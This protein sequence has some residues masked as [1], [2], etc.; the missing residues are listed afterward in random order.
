M[1]YS[2]PS[3]LTKCLDDPRVLF[4]LP[5]L[6]PIYLPHSTQHLILCEIQRILEEACFKFTLKWAAPLLREKKWECPAS[7]E[8]TTWLDFFSREK[9]HFQPE[10]FSVD[11]TR[12]HDIFSAAIPIRHTAVHRLR[13]PMSR[14]QDLCQHGFDLASALGD[15]TRA[16]KIRDITRE[17]KTQLKDMEVKKVALE[18]EVVNGL[19]AILRQRKIL[20]EKQKEL[21]DDMACNDAQ[22]TAHVGSLLEDETRKIL[23]GCPSTKN[24][25]RLLSE[26]AH[27]TH[28]LPRTSESTISTEAVEGSLLPWT[29][30]KFAER[31]D[32]VLNVAKMTY[33]TLGRFLL[34]FLQ[35]VLFLPNFIMS[36]IE[37]LWL[38][39]AHSPGCDP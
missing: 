39:V 17:L 3:Y 29:E 27:V 11:P 4:D 2:A 13:L 34:Y 37:V 35:C 28:G 21:I 10:L 32:F 26:D 18:R 24:T 38:L 30:L 6:H 31:L 7:A 22:N 16:S 36:S 25:S 15:T 5:L 20:D 23:V 19:V 9:R 12:I 33:Q 8:L 1:N 14:V